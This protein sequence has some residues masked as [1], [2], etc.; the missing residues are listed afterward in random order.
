MS[1]QHTGSA[2]RI[3]LF[4]V[5]LVGGRVQNAKIMKETV[6]YFKKPAVLGPNST[7]SLFS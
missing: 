3:R 2:Q 1:W 7:G 5:V 6:I 4:L